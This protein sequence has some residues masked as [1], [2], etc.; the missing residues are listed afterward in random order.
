MI[1]VPGLKAGRQPVELAEAGG[2]PGDV[3]AGFVQL[4]DAFEALFQQVLDV[5]E[6]GRDAALREVEHDLLG[7]VDEHLR[8]A[9][10]LPAELRDLLAGGDQAA[11]RRHLAD[12]ACVVRG[13]R[14][15]RHERCELVHPHASAHVLELAAF[16]ELVDERDRVDR[17]TL[18]IEREP[19]A[20]D[21]GVTCAVEVRR[22]EDFAHRPDRTRGEQHRPEDRFFGLEVLRWCDRSGFC[23]LGDR[24]HSFGVDHPLHGVSICG[25][26]SF[27]HVLFRLFAAEKNECSHA[28][29]TES[30]DGSP[31]TSGNFLDKFTPGGKCC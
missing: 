23:E 27:R 12:D 19:G 5:A 14:R 2:D 26:R 9:R 24:C 6:L 30:V 7:A 28:V 1:E 29:R 13:V 10:A 22:V 4:S 15:R 20:I 8:L 18:R 17:L 16:L 21:L 31:A 25:T 11:E 3:G